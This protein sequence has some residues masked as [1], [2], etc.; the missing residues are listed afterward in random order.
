M[1][2]VILPQF[3]QGWK[4]CDVS[5]HTFGTFFVDMVVRDVDRAAAAAKVAWF[6]PPIYTLAFIG[7]FNELPKKH[8]G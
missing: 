8:H 3:Q 1:T 4:K 2:V 5:R 6:T 7:N